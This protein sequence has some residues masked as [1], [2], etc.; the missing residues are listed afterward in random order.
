MYVKIKVKSK[1]IYKDYTHVCIRTY[2][3]AYIKEK[4]HIPRHVLSIENLNKTNLKNVV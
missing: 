3:C 4:L 2:K 1:K